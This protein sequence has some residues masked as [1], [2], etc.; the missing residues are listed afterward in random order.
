MINLVIQ[1]SGLFLKYSA[2]YLYLYLVGRSFILLLNR[3]FKNQW[4]IE[5]HTLLVKNKILLP[6]LGLALVGN[7][8]IILNFFIPLKSQ[9]V[10][11]FLS[12][13][14]LPNIFNMNNLNTNYLSFRSAFYFVILPIILLVSSYDVG[15]HYDAGYYH[16]NHQN[17]LRE[18]NLIFGMV[19]IF[20]P[21]GMSSIYEYF[22]AVLWVDKSFISL[23]LLTVLFIHFFYLL[24]IDNLVDSKNQ[25][26][27]N[28]SFFLLGFSILDNFG[29]Q[30]GRNGFLFIQGVGKQDI[31]VGVL[32]FL[33]SFM[34]LIYTL[35]QKISK[36]DLAVLSI[37]TLF[38]FQIKV[39][40]VFVG[41][42]YIIL[43]VSLLISK[44]FKFKDLFS[45]H[46]PVLFLAAVSFIKSFLTTGCLIFPLTPTCRNNFD[47]YVKGST[48]I[49]EG[50]T[51]TSSL[52]FIDYY[53]DPKRTYLDWL[54]DM[55][56]YEFYRAVLFNFLM[57][58]T[59][60]IVAKFLIFK[61]VKQNKKFV[62]LLFPFILFN[63]IYLVFYGPIPRYSIGIMLI[64][65]SSIS[66]YAGEFKFKF[67]SW[68]YYSL[69]FVSAL[70][71]VRIGSYS[72]LLNNQ[73]Y[74]VFNPREVA[75]YTKINDSWVIPDEGDQCWINLECSM[76]KEYNPKLV[77]VII[78]E[79]KYFKTVY[80]VFDTP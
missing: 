68:V 32:F 44:H 45:A 36:K 6:I 80:R 72:E 77:D 38:V 18:S 10:F 69:V 5:D 73:S 71:I 23:H 42:L 3:I 65:I 13:L 16:L 35:E 54:A 63:S 61:S 52:A 41:Y 7:F 14:L 60:L 22:S 57:S 34:C 30:G 74:K 11:I 15:F 26:L 64:M 39:S 2:I 49:Y 24:L 25:K 17:W 55:L 70:F 8:L 12:I 78:S 67:N 46:I 37:L 9:S 4:E 43:F 66:F 62:F 79:G 53:H 40:G 28:A 51:K 33:I 19:N 21:F 31:A 76:A 48:E 59:I 47:W 50:I 58:I 27:R 29:F 20:W 1:F 75:I 56:A